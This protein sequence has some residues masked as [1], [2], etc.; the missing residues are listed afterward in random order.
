MNT[1]AIAGPAIIPPWNIVRFMASAPGS[2]SRGTRR[3]KSA[4]RAGLSNDPA[5]EVSPVR[6]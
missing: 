2:A 5:A 4:W 1:P 3:G 6:T